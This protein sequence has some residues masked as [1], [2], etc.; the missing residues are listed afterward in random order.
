MR[1]GGQDEGVPPVHRELS[2]FAMAVSDVVWRGSVPG[3]GEPPARRDRA[4][5]EATPLR[6]AASRRLAQRAQLRERL[7]SEGI[8]GL[9]RWS[10]WLLALTLVLFVVTSLWLFFIYIQAVI[11]DIYFHDRPCDVPLK[12]Y[13]PATLFWRGLHG[14]LDGFLRERFELDAAQSLLMA[15]MAFI[16]SWC[17][18]GW[19]FYMVHS[20][21]KCADTNPNLFYP[22]RNC[23]HAQI[24]FSLAFA[25]SGLIW[26]MGIRRV[27]MII[28]QLR[29]QSSSCVNAVKKLP[30]VP[31]DSPLLVDPEDGEAMEC[32]FCMDSLSQDVSKE[33]VLTPCKH[34]FHEECLAVWAKGHLDCPICRQQMGEED[35]MADEAPDV[36]V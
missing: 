10:W 23:V 34:Y 11:A 22:T 29:E 14:P 25:F 5:S 7:I 9:G 32:V 30:K 26:L 1:G 19:G 36:P 12:W 3:V 24:V 6:G 17:L 21:E 35:G 33:V 28:M 18:I 20:S 2:E 8:G 16:P 15:V 31:H 27:V 13:V 4:P